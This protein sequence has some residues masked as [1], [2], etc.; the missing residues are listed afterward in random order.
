MNAYAD[1]I[2]NTST[3]NAPWFIIPADNKWFSRI[4]VS[5][6]IIQKLESLDMHYPTVTEQHLESLLEAKKILESE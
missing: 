2:G 6:I 5:E 1:A 3:K 4:A